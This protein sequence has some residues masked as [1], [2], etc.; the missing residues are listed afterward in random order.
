[1]LQPD[2]SVWYAD[3]IPVDCKLPAFAAIPDTIKLCAWT[4]GDR[5][6]DKDGACYASASTVRHN[7]T[8]H[9]LG[10]LRSRETYKSDHGVNHALYV[11]CQAKYGERFENSARRV[12][13]EDSNFKGQVWDYD[14]DKDRDQS[15]RDKCGVPKP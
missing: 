7:F 2:H 13:C 10:E 1:M 11:V 15:L 4:V 6:G 14:P 5:P 8:G 9:W 3:G 12:L